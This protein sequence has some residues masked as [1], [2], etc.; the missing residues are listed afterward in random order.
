MNLSALTLIPLQIC[1]QLPAGAQAAI[2][3]IN[4]YVL[5]VVIALFVTV[6]IVGIG[7]IVAGRLFAMPHVTKGGVVTLVVAAVAA[8]LMPVVLP[9]IQGLLGN[10]CIG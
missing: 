8:V 7:M 10:G 4:G 3:T 1:P 5:G 9:I 6:V 2:D